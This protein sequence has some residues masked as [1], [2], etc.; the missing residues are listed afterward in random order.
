LPGFS[1][2]CKKF[3]HN[4]PDPAK[5]T[6]TDDEIRKQFGVT[7]PSNN[8]LPKTVQEAVNQKWIK[9][10]ENCIEGSRYISPKRDYSNVLLFD[11]S[12]KIAG[13]QIGIPHVP[14]S[15]MKDRYYEEVD[16]GGRKLWTL[17]SFFVDPKTICGQRTA[18]DFGDRVWWRSKVDEGGFFKLP[19]TIK[20]VNENKNWVLGQCVLGMGLHYWYKIS[21]NMNCDDFTPFFVMYNNGKLTTFAVGF[22]TKDLI[23][24]PDSRFEHAPKFAIRLNFKEET[25]PQCLMKDETK[26]STMHFMFT[27]VFSNRCQGNDKK[28]SHPMENFSK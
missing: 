16:F 6:G 21:S 13:V 25:L 8:D 4:F 22:G 19:L 17:T 2:I 11:K 1:F 23:N 27:S 28:L 18:K 26:V 9:L 14:P 20:E 15:P 7:F 3:H 5:A 24:T 12:N 10:S